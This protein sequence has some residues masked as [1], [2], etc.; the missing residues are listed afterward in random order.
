MR[1]TSPHARIQQRVEQRRQAARDTHVGVVQPVDL[2]RGDEL[3][4]A[5][6]ELVHH[7]PVEADGMVQQPVEAVD[8]Q[9][10]H[11]TFAQRLDV[12]AVGFALEGRA[13]AEP[14]AGRHAGEGH[15]LALGVVAA[16]LEQA[17][18]HAKPV[19]HRP[20]DAADV[21]A[22]VGVAHQQRRHGA[23][24]F[25]GLQLVQPRNAV[26]LFSRGGPAPLVQG[27]ILGRAGIHGCDRKGRYGKS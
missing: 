19:G 9:P 15:G 10:G 1:S 8:R 24:T 14:A 7:E 13:L 5:F 2:A 12:V 22:R 27:Q 18:D 17:L 6:V 4:E 11:H 21:V 26:Q 3:S 25:G 20:P 16:H 23:F